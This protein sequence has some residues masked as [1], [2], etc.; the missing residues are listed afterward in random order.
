MSI[1]DTLP[2][3]IKRISKI[4][5]G[6]SQTTLPLGALDS[7]YEQQSYGRAAAPWQP[8]ARR[9]EWKD[10]CYL[11]KLSTLCAPDAFTAKQDTQ[12]TGHRS[13]CAE[14]TVL[15]PNLDSHRPNRLPPLF[16]ITQSTGNIRIAAARVWKRQ[17]RFA[18]RITRNPQPTR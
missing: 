9:S 1:L 13:R 4:L 12:L 8:E 15:D 14:N 16:R 2:L 18:A 6:M 3:L 5:I 11:G 7:N 17:A 10:P